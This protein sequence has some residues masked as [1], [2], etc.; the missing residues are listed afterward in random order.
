MSS[1]NKVCV[2]VA[3]DDDYPETYELEVRVSL[4]GRDN[5]VLTKKLARKRNDFESLFE[6]W[7][8]RITRE[9]M[10]VIQAEKS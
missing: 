4:Q 6:Y 8:R 9:I 10:E 3:P 1:I 2:T 5:E 7:M